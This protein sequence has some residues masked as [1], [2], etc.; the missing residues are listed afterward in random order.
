MDSVSENVILDALANEAPELSRT[1]IVIA[2][3][4]ATIKNADKIIYLQD[5]EVCEQGTHAELMSITQ[6]HYRSLVEAQDLTPM[7]LDELEEYQLA[8]IGSPLEKQMTE[9]FPEIVGESDDS[10]IHRSTFDLIARCVDLSR[11]EWL[12]IYVGLLAA[13]LSGGIVVGEAVV[14]G[15]LI[16]VLTTG[17]K[18][19]NA[20]NEASRYCIVFLALA[21]CALA[22]Y[23]ASGTC[24]GIVSENLVLKTRD[25]SLRT[26]LQQDVDWFSRSGN[27]APS[28]IAALSTDAGHLSGL[29]GVIIGTVFSGTT[30]VFGGIILAHIVAWK[31]AIVLLAAVP[32][33]LLAGF[34]RL[35]VLA[36]IQ[37]RHE[38][39]YNS[40]TAL[41]SEAC[42]KIR[43]VASLSQEKPFFSKYREAIE[44]PY[45]ASIKHSV[46]GNLLLAFSLAITYV[47][48]SML[49]TVPID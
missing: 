48:T 39:A 5:G 42:S 14:F 36:N 49:V 1:T 25:I 31:I 29:S 32:I 4:L 20:V 6:G 27:S 19:A 41:A 8:E 30:S 16:S 23:I 38:T 12:Y 2:H 22:A 37:R 47:S 13:V 18:P 46:I 26:I 45:R 9:I 43:T 40:A 44:A 17:S 28:L 15:N 21:I 7:P 10:A 11:G 24:F 3:R 35:R 33:M 34:F